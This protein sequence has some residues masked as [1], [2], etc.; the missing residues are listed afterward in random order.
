MEFFFENIIFIYWCYKKWLY[1]T[2]IITQAVIRNDYILKTL[3]KSWRQIVSHLNNVTDIELHPIW[4][5]IL[6]LQFTD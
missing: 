4:R 1:G 2:E 3:Q 6:S 5:Q